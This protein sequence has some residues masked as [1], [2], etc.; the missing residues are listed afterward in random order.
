SHSWRAST[1]NRLTETLY[2]RSSGAA[3]A[4]DEFLRF[5]ARDC[6][7]RL[8]RGVARQ[9][10]RNPL[11]PAGETPINRTQPQTPR[12]TRTLVQ[13]A[14]GEWVARALHAAAELG[15]ADRLANVPKSAAELAVPMHVHALSLHRFMRTL[16][17]LGVLAERPEQRYALTTLGEALRTGAPG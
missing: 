16:A 3:T 11:T 12:P 15:L 2:S 4:L 8:D 1:R 13:M 6:A 7:I 5:V 9:P 14:T 10:H 17:S